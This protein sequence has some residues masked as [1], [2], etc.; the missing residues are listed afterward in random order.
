MPYPWPSWQSPPIFQSQ[1]TALGAGGTPPSPT[2]S[3]QADPGLQ[4][5]WAGCL[6][7]LAQLPFNPPEAGDVG[8]KRPHS[9]L[10]Q[11]GVRPG[12]DPSWL[13]SRARLDQR[14]PESEGSGCRRERPEA[15][16]GPG[17]GAGCSSKTMTL[18]I[19]GI[20]SPLWQHRGAGAGWGVARGR[21]AS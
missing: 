21:P 13:C 14:S 17:G 16:T 3:R 5:W 12:A 1:L 18:N 10:K 15:F 6:Q 11:L 8:E 4:V 19:C 7:G 20:C 2:D 9:G